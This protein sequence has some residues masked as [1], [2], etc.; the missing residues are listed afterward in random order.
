MSHFK[1]TAMVRY[2]DDPIIWNVFEDRISPPD[3]DYVWDA[4]R[5]VVFLQEKKTN[6]FGEAC[7]CER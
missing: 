1:K 7:F 5:M 3:W 4:E 2:R 6:R